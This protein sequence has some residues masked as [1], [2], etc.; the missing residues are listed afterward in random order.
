[1]PDIVTDYLTLILGCS[2]ALLLVVWLATGIWTY[3]DARSR[4]RSAAT[5]F[6]AAAFVLLVPIAGLVVYLLLRPRE[7]LIEMYDRALEQEALLQQIEE[8]L[9]CPGCSRRVA[10]TWIVCPDCR[11]Q[12]RRPCP[13]CGRPLDL[14]WQICPY[15]AHEPGPTFPDGDAGEN[16]P[17]GVRG[18][19]ETLDPVTD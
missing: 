12:L 6:L 2:G 11:T 8:P 5:A 7:T 18:P 10:E 13:A 3:R 17:A 9:V 4:S 14:R 19:E 1:M 15:C 16:E